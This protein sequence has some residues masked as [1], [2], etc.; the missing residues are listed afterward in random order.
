MDIENCAD[1][2]SVV[3]DTESISVI[4]KPPVDT[5]RTSDLPRLPQTGYFVF[6]EEKRKTL[7]EDFPGEKVGVIAKKLGKLWKNL[8]DDEKESYKRVAQK[9]K[10]LN[11]NRSSTNKRN[12]SNKE[13]ELPVGKIRKIIKLDE[14]VEKVSKDAILAI[15]KST[16]FFLEELGKEAEKFKEGS[17]IKEK[18]LKEAIHLGSQLF[19]FLRYDFPLKTLTQTKAPSK[20]S[21]VPMDD[22]KGT[23]T[24]LLKSNFATRT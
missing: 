24:G 16:E 4:I 5:F 23:L 1:Q 22:V 7:M 15:A 21:P 14:E 19:S 2:M 10:L 17:I 18:N 8:S 3:S 9:N 6:A 11:A 12:A 13:V 20:S